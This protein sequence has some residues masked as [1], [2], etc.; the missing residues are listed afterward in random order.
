[1]DRNTLKNV[2]GAVKTN[3]Q[4]WLDQIL[5][6]KPNLLG[7]AMMMSGRYRQN[8]LIELLLSRGSSL[9]NAVI[10]SITRKG[11]VDFFYE[12]FKRKSHPP[13]HMDKYLGGAVRILNIEVCLYLLDD[14]KHT[15]SQD[16]VDKLC[17]F[18]Q[19]K[20]YSIEERTTRFNQAHFTKKISTYD[21]ILKRLE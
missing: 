10:G 12:L 16:V 3:N 5:T 21:Q 18:I 17:L 11:D 19:R 8:G 9:H 2:R 1:M 13:E 6:T 14:C 7:Y 15:P 20:I 4:E